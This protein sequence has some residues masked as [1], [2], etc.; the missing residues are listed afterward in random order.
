MRREASTQGRKGI[1]DRERAR[2]AGGEPG[3]ER[4][5]GQP[6]ASEVEDY[7]QSQELDPAPKQRAHYSHPEPPRI[8]R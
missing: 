5:A 8:R 6:Y 2:A 7:A 1:S 4:E 3:S